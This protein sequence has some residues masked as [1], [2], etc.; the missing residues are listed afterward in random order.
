MS[1]YL[2]ALRPVKTVAGSALPF[3]WLLRV[4]RVLWGGGREQSGLHS[5]AIAASL[6]VRQ[7]VCPRVRVSVLY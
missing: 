1:T 7:C 4:E 2:R 5:F 6:R 3:S